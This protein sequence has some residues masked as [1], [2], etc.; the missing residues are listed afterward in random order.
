V[1]SVAA[2]VAEIVPDDFVDNQAGRL[3]GTMR[4]IRA[5]IG[6]AIAQAR[7]D[8]ATWA[9]A[10]AIEGVDPRDIDPADV[11]KVAP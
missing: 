9:R 2:I 3:K 4:A 8:G 6:F 7:E 1:T 11:R 10:Q 5:D